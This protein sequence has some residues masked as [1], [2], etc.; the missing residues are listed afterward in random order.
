MAE[1]DGLMRNEYS[2]RP[3]PASSVICGFDAMPVIIGI[4]ASATIFMLARCAELQCAPSIATT[5]AST[6]LLATFTASDGI[7][8][9][10]EHHELDLAAAQQTTGGVD[11]LDGEIDAPHFPFRGDGRDAGLRRRDADHDRLRHRRR[12]TQHAGDSSRHPDFHPSS[13]PSAHAPRVP[14][15]N[16]AGGV[17][18]MREMRWAAPVTS[19]STL[20]K[21]RPESRY[22]GK[23]TLNAATTL[24]ARSRMGA[25]DRQHAGNI[26]FVDRGEALSPHLGQGSDQGGRIGDGMGRDGGELAPAQKLARLAV[27]QRCQQHLAG[28]GA[29][30]RHLAAPD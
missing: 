10:V 30:Q 8:L 23:A 7:A 14:V 4:L 6:S 12:N 2:L 19:G 5:L 24:P 28:A 25:A 13:C 20:C 3:G 29:V 16:I 11:L 15:N 1:S 18:S 26:L 22:L 27:A 21:V 17:P 9:V